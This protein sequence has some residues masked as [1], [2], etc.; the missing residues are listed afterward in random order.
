MPKS[1]STGYTI[2]EDRHLCGVFLDI[3]QN[4]SV[5]ANQSRVQ[6]WKCVEDKYNSEKPNSTIPD[7]NQ[8][9]LQ[10]RMQTILKDAR[11]FNGCLQQAESLNPSGANEQILLEHAKELLM[12]EKGY[13]NGF[14]FEHVWFILKDFV[15]SK[16]TS[17][18]SSFPEENMLESPI[19]PNSSMSSFSINLSDENSSGRSSRRPEAVKNSK[20]KRKS[21]EETSTICAFKEENEKL[22]ELLLSSIGK[23]DR[24]VQMKKIEAQNRKSEIKEL[25]REDNILMIN[26]DTISDLERREF[27]RLEQ[28]YIM[29]KRRL[30]QQPSSSGK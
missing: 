13:N 18:V 30:A 22:R 23:K 27:F 29:Q 9:S 8:R 11:K 12:Q 24:E 10:C 16:T 4:E 25:V 19:S 26:L 20:L 2:A 6:F 17:G 14:K 28:Q 5:G 15:Q 3:S 21:S 7:R 1:R